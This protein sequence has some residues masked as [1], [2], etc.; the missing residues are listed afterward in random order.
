M[1][2]DLLVTRGDGF[3]T[4]TFNRP[5]A[6]NALTYAMYDGLAALC[7]DPG[8]DAKAV[9]VT[10]AGPD[11]F[12]AGTDIAQFESLSTA[13]DSLAYEAR[14]EV[15]LSAIERCPVPTIA[16]IAGACTGGGAAIAGC[17]DLRIGAANIKYGF[18]IAR[19]LGNC[20]SAA[21]LG[22]LVALMGEPRVKDM[23]LTARL[24]EA[25]EARAIGLVSRIVAVEALRDEAEALARTIAGLAPLTLSATRQALLRQR[26][27]IAPADDLVQLCY[28]SGDFRDA[29]T[30][31]GKKRKPMWRG[32]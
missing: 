5:K 1:N 3:V 20:L 14:I 18:P 13:A 11:A 23:L 26:K 9:I 2:D 29:V 15:V 7:A 6:R 24:I 30:A 31:F 28:L 10:G 21:N 17:C 12:A 27:A 32:E 22:R 4:A 16:A 8:A 19:T 25:D